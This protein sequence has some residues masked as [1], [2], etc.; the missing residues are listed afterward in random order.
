[1]LFCLLFQRVVIDALQCFS[2]C[3]HR[4]LAGEKG[5]IQVSD[6]TSD[7]EF[8][9]EEDGDGIRLSFSSTESELK[10][11]WMGTDQ[12]SDDESEQKKLWAA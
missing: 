5:Y 10:E 6:Q 11:Q 8:E 1:M 4:T 7:D 9:M 12:A 2:A 3:C